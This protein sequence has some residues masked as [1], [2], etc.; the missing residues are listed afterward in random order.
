[1]PTA[2][3]IVI[4]SVLLSLCLCTSAQTTPQ[5]EITRIEQGLF[6]AWMTKDRAFLDRVIAPEWSVID[7]SGQMLTRA[8]V[9]ASF[10]DGTRVLESGEISDLQIRVYGSTAV[11]T[12]RS[13]ANGRANG[14]AVSIRQRFTDVFVKNAV[15]WQIVASQAT[16]DQSNL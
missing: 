10:S 2:R 5:D 6:K 1:M 15:G 3:I 7:A 8:A 4:L 11:V 12:G 16:R 14:T 9:I 13:V